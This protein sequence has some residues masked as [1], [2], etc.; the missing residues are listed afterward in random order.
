MQR[1]TPLPHPLFNSPLISHIAFPLLSFPIPHCYPNPLLNGNQVPYQYVGL[2]PVNPANAPVDEVEELAAPPSS[3]FRWPVNY[4]FLKKNKISF[5]KHQNHSQSND[6]SPLQPPS[7][8][9][10]PSHFLT[11]ACFTTPNY[12][13]NHRRTSNCTPR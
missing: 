6:Q 13:K 11:F 3:R 7:L 8:L 9:Q 4:F 5:S 1:L 12:K 10:L 2:N